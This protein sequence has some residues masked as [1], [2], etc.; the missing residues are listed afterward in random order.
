MGAI[1]Q[2]LEGAKYASQKARG[3]PT[4]SVASDQPT[5]DQSDNSLN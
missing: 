5:T 1:G 3:I 4:D 2:G